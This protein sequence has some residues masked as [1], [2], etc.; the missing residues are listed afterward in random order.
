MS[1]AALP[2]LT[3]DTLEA[4]TSIRNASTTKR[5]CTP[6]GCICNDTR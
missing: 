3:I 2:D 6:P 4:G 5:T 1:A